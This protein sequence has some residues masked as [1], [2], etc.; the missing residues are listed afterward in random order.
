MQNIQ[1]YRVAKGL[2]HFSPV[3]IQPHAMRNNAARRL[4]SSRDKK[5][6]PVDG[7]ESEDVFADQMQRRPELLKTNCSFAFFISKAYGRRVVRQS[8][9][10]HVHRVRRIIRNWYAPAY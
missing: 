8:F 2:G 6:G 3:G 9:E 10:P 1:L 5:G 4:H 7:V